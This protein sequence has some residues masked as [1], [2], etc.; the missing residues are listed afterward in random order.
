MDPTAVLLFLC[1]IAL[2]VLINRTPSPAAASSSLSSA[3]RA[4]KR[5]QPGMGLCGSSEADPVQ[6]GP[7]Q[8][9]AREVAG[10]SRILDNYRTLQEVEMGLRKAGLESSDLIIG[11]DFTKSNL[12][13][14]ERSFGNRSLHALSPLEP[15]GQLNPNNSNPYQQVISTLADVLLKRLDDDCVSG[16]STLWHGCGPTDFGPPASPAE[17]S[18]RWQMTVVSTP[19]A[20]R[21]LRPVVCQGPGPLIPSSTLSG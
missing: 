1:F 17:G 2:V 7:N 18:A 14:G 19:S 6:R 4:N 16:Q 9:Q 15:G 12:W 13:Q 8:P 10:S 5:Q 21:L 3:N 20:R 11:V